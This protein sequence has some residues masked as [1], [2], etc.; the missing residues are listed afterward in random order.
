MPPAGLES[1]ISAGKR[2]QNYALDRT[3]VGTGTV[4]LTGTLHRSKEP[5]I[6]SGFPQPSRPALRPTQS[7]VQ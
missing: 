4:G 6:G 5:T 1:T 7:P 2:R 3:A